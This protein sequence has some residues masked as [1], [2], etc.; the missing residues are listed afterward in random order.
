MENQR[1]IQEAQTRYEDFADYE[2]DIVNMIS[3]GR[4][5]IDPRGEDSLDLYYM[6]AKKKRAEKD[7]PVQKVEDG[8]VP[9]TESAQKKASSSHEPDY[10]S[11]TLEE[12]EKSIGV[13][14]WRHSR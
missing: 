9:H 10:D 2:E 14:E 1:R 3:K 5:G 12:M 6:L 11:M 7:K 8:K 13:A 4:S